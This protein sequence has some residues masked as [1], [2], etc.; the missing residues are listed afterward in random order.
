MNIQ[1]LPVFIAIIVGVLVIWAAL[2][3]SSKSKALVPMIAAFVVF[4]VSEFAGLILF[5]NGQS[6]DWVIR[7]YYAASVYCLACISLYAYE[8]SNLEFRFFKPVILALSTI[9]ALLCVAS[10]LIVTGVQLGASSPT[11]EK[12]PAYLM[13]QLYSL[14]FLVMIVTLLVGGYRKARCHK[15]QAQCTYTIIAVMPILATCFIMLSLMVVDIQFAAI[16]FFPVAAIIFMGITLIS[17]ERHQL[18]DIRRFVPGSRER[19]TSS[20]VMHVVSAYSRDEVSYRDAVSEIERMLVLHKYQ[21]N[22]GNASA[23]AELMGMPRSSLY[24]IF[25]R[26]NIVANK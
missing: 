24:S 10:D 5:R 23:T 9:F 3:G 6:L 4:H 8:V 13:F 15:I 26:L 18:T 16:G 1:M 25:N 20:K 21:K 19:L 14:C 17:E 12:G 22:G 2:L 7:I 11:A